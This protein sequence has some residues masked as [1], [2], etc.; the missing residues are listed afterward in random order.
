M[1]VPMFAKKVEIT[2]AD[3][4]K[5]LVAPI[6]FSDCA[7]YIMWFKW[8]PFEEGKRR[9]KDLDNELR[10]QLLSELFDECSKKVWQIDD[11]LIMESLTSITG[12]NKMM[13][14]SLRH[15]YPDM[16]EEMVS[17]IVTPNNYTEILDKVSEISGLADKENKAS[18]G[19]SEGQQAEM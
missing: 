6:T 16:T 18:E 8:L 2:G 9:T 19:N 4:N 7:E 13:H 17:H 12:I 15:H 1:F 11:A 10:A 14:L 3:G 5:Y